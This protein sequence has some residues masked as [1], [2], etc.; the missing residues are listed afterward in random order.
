MAS[1]VEGVL[2]FAS[3]GGRYQIENATEVCDVTSGDH[4]DVQLGGQ[5]IAGNVEHGSVYVIGRS[6][7]PFGGYYFLAGNDGLMCGLCLGMKVRLYL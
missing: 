6:R 5:W 2:S 1:Y 4:L 3:N 7:V